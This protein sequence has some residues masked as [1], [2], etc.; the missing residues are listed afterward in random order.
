MEN[1]MFIKNYFNGNSIT[2]NTLLNN[3]EFLY[4]KLKQVFA[5]LNISISIQDLKITSGY[6]DKQHNKLV[7]G[8]NNSLHTKGLAVDFYDPDSFLDKILINNVKLLRENQC[9]IE[10]PAYTKGWCHFQ[11][12][13]PKSQ[14]SVFIPYNGAIKTNQ[15]DD[16]FKI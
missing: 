8:A 16:L 15:K 14:K 6:R 9:A 13:L 1:N 2:D 3:C 10:H 5:S 11:A 4:N 12:V 7:G